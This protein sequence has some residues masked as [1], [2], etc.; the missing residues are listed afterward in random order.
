MLIY[1]C[2]IDNLIFNNLR[3][4]IVYLNIQIFVQILITYLLKNINTVSFTFTL[5]QF[6]NYIGYLRIINVGKCPV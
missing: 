4:K 5:A 1:N 6:C 2:I 3:R